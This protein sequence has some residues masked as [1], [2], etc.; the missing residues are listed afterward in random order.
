ML[1]GKKRLVRGN[2]DLFK[3][4]LYLEYF[5]EIYGVRQINGVWLSHAPMALEC[6]EGKRVKL[7]AHG[8]LHANT[9]DHPKYRNV[10]VEQIDYTPISLDELVH[11]RR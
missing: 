11:E 4:R 6:V 7:N 2:H 5:Q 8:H 9:I 1:N 3:T 10:C